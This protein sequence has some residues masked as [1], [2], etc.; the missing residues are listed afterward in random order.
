MAVSHSIPALAVWRFIAGLSAAASML[1]ASGLIMQHL[2]QLGLKP[3]LG[4]HF[5]GLGLGI[6]LVAFCS[7]VMT[8]SNL[9]SSSQWFFFALLAMLLLL[10]AWLLLPPV[11]P[12]P[13]VASSVHAETLPRSLLPTVF[14]DV[15]LRR[16]RLCGFHHFYRRCC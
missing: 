9:L 10:P 5:A 1:L 13:N 14:V 12:V 8:Q 16:L 3:E 2:R 4:W 15:F 6:V 7:E 11:S